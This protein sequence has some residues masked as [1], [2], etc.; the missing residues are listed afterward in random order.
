MG[1]GKIK[2]DKTDGRCRLQLAVSDPT[3][4][5]R[6]SVGKSFRKNPPTVAAIICF[7]AAAAAAALSGAAASQHAI[8][9]SASGI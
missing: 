3:T 6:E 9:L 7:A 2:L 8:Q 1:W 4:Y 5:K